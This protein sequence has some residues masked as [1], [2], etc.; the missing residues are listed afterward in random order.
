[1]THLVFVFGTLKEGFPNFA[2]N[3]GKRVAGEFS[4]VKRYPLYLIG[5]RF[6]PWLVFS[7]GEGERVAGQVFE[8]DQ[9]ALDA[10]DVL[11]RVTE[12]DGYRRVSIAVE[13]VD[14]ESRSV[15]SVQ[16][17]VKAPEHFRAADVKA[18]PLGEYT[19]EHAGLYRSRP[20]TAER[21]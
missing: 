10:M 13:R 14:G 4:T 8:V 12:A 7:A 11:E 3:R 16:A 20:A 1:M 5:E 21:R 15:L 17:Y 19:M 2:T 6:S 18:G 9:G